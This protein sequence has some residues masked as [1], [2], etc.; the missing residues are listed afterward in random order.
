MQGTDELEGK[1]EERYGGRM[2]GRK[3]DEEKEG[4][5]FGH[6]VTARD[7]LADVC[8]RTTAWLLGHLRGTRSPSFHRSPLRNCPSQIELQSLDTIQLG[9]VG[10]FANPIAVS[11]LSLTRQVNAARTRERLR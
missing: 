10:P 2:C 9:E 4:L 11:F 5:T 8:D 1:R 3:E 6:S 7:E